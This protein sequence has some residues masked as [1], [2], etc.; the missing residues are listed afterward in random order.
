MGDYHGRNV[1]IAARWHLHSRAT[2]HTS[3]AIIFFCKA[4]FLHASVAI[5]S[6]AGASVLFFN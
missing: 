2:F 6:F 3:I 4:N 1:L 5:R